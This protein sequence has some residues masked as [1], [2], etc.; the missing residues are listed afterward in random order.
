[1]VKSFLRALSV[2]MLIIG[3][4]IGAGFASGR[5]VVAF[6]G[7]EPNILTALITG[8]LV[9]GCSV[10]FLWVGMRVKKSDIGEV[11]GAIFK[12]ARPVADVFILFNSMIVLGAMLAATDSLCAEFID[13]RPLPSILVGIVCAIIAVKGLDGVI[14]TNAVLVP[15]MLVVLSVCCIAAID[16]PL[17]PRADGINIMSVLL[18]VSMN[19]ILSGGVLST[20]NKLSRREIL[21]ACAI[22]SV[23]IA[24]LLLFIMGALQ[25]NSAAHADMPMLL[26][27]LKS[28]KTAY[29][30]CLPIIGASIFTTMLTAF[31]SVYDYISGFIKYRLVVAGMVLLAGLVIGAFGF[32]SVVN[33]I[34]PIIGGIGF[35]YIACNGV[36]LI[37]TRVRKKAKK[38]KRVCAKKVKRIKASGA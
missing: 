33:R 27:A 10:L 16:F 2:A 35:I 36:Y 37:K 21:L 28:G 17:K 34:Y 26:I 31:K 13:L 6:F 29:F 8:V 20:V 18:Y 12:K 4:M 25:S 1:M 7:A 14:K 38:L 19:M 9:F 3:T 5:E 11:N 32:S 30:V 24:G 15:I 23:V 22:A